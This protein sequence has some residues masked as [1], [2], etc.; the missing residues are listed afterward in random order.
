MTGESIV[1]APTHN[2]GA[3]VETLVHQIRAACGAIDILFIDDHSTD[4]TRDT[5][6]RL[7]AT[8]PHIRWHYR[9]AKLGLGTALKTGMQLALQGGWT[10]ILQMDGDLSHDAADLPRLLVLLDDVDVV[11][12]SRYLPAGAVEGWGVSR[13]LIS[14]AGCLYARTLLDLPTLDLT[15]GFVGYRRDALERIGLEQVVSRG[16]AFQIEMKFFAQRAGLH[17]LEVPI[18][19][20]DRTKGH[21]K[22]APGIILEA[23]WRVL[24]LRMSSCGY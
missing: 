18:V 21:S 20:R 5:I 24:R 6:E 4:G 7:A 19:F 16:Y 10:K 8:D 1:L 17:V 2:E 13:R 22:L 3:N 14:G 23:A 9:E 12:G 11:V 15:S